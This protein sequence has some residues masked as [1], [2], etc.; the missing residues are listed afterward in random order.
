MTPNEE[1]PPRNNGCF[2][3]SVIGCVLFALVLCTVA[4]LAKQ[5]FIYC[6]G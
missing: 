3:G 6:F 5:A 2:L 4:Y 1:I